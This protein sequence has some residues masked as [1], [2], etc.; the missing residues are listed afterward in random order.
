MP[1][2]PRK[3]S[4][5]TVPSPGNVVAFDP[6]RRRAA[7][8]AALPSP[9]TDDGDAVL[10]RLDQAM[11]LLLHMEAKDADPKLRARWKSAIQAALATTPPTPVV[12]GTREVAAFQGDVK[13]LARLTDIADYC[14]AWL[15][16]H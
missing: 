7:A 15:D 4:P 6:S 14:N 2:K 10:F 9:A 5:G 11:I 13:L 1:R 16:R 8:V 3:P 12:A